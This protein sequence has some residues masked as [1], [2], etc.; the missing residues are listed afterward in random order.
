M[1]S[2]AGWVSNANDSVNVFI[3]IKVREK[4]RKISLLQTAS[5]NRFNIYFLA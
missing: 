2:F 5:K 3:T 1:G 4:E